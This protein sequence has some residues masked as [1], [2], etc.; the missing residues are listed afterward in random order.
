MAG[1]L[2]RMQGLDPRRNFSLLKPEGTRRVGKHQLGWFESV[3][4][5][6]KNMDVRKL[7]RK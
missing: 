5:D 6:L 7:R 4:E 1:T 2:L 3:A